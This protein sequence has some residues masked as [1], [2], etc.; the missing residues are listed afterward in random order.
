VMVTVSVAFSPSSS[1]TSTVAVC[2]P[3]VRN[4]CVTLEPNAV[5]SANVHLYEHFGY[6][7][8]GHARVASTLETWGMFR[9]R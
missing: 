8:H 6:H 9:P 4:V 1:F 3:S 7:V 2:S 5:P